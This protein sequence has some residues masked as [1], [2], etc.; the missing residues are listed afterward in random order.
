ME[1]L[2][3]LEEN[4]KNTT[5]IYCVFASSIKKEEAYK[6]IT[7]KPIISKESVIY[8]IEKFTDKQVF[9]ENLDIE[10][11]VD[12]L[13]TLSKSYKNANIFTVDA[14]YQLL[15]NKK[16][17]MKIIKG[18]ATKKQEIK[19]HNNI[20]QYI[21]EENKPCDFLIEL[22]V[23]NKDGKVLSKYYDKF[24]QINK[25]LEI[26]DDVVSKT[27]L[28][29]DYKI[30]DFGCGKAYLTFAL[31]YYFYKIKKVNVSIVGLDLK[32]DVIEFCNN[33]ARKLQYN[34][35][36]FENGDI[37]DYNTNLNIDLV[38]TL[39]A[40]DNATDAALVKAITWNTDLILSVPCCQ[41]EF[42]NKINNLNL[43]PM[44][45]HGLIKERLSS[46]V[47]DSLRGLFLE[48]KGYK[49]QMVEF[50][51]MEHTPKNILIRAVKTKI[52][53]KAKIDYEKFKSFYNLE[54]IFIEN[55][56]NSQINEKI[57]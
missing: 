30:I 50:V 29:E 6:K 10:F 38:V 41:H 56:Y 9:H 45:K 14:D 39:H 3:I 35:L 7:V 52:N 17:N 36:K 13:V 8:Q 27:D 42:Y 32:T 4:I 55:Y 18:K 49:V 22:G 15:V 47:T 40:C 23:M 5:L 54:N 16:G 46:L 12:R 44:L 51:D 19:Y 57:N 21:I 53:E 1:L 48:A 33:V 28:K 20:K 11:I 25:F 26:V 34:H 43:E 31:Y 24:K 2:E 37:K